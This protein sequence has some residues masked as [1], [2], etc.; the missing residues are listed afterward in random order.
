MSGIAV[1]GLPNLLRYN[2][3]RASMMMRCLA[4]HWPQRVLFLGGQIRQM[5]DEGDD[6]PDLFIGVCGAESGHGRHSDAMFDDPEEFS[7]CVILSVAQRWRMGID[8]FG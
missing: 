4:G 6:F 2:I 3:S 1:S 5:A 8:S 7:V